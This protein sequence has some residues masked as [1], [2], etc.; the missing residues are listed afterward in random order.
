MSDARLGARSGAQQSA[1][2]R[3][4]GKVDRATVLNRA[5]PPRATIRPPCL[6][7]LGEPVPPAAAM[8][9]PWGIRAFERQY[10]E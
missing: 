3:A 9:V 7:D 6:E 1:S 2:N 8:D 5:D 10:R 4:R